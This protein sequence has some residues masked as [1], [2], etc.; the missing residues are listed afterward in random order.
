MKIKKI[1]IILCNIK[2]ANVGVNLDQVD[3][4]IFL[5]QELN[6][7]EN[8]QVESRFFPTQLKLEKLLIYIT[9]IVFT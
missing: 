6:P 3:V 4:I 8:E 7:T 1:N 9:L 2:T 5:D